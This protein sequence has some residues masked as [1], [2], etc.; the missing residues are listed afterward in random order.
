LPAELL[1]RPRPWIARH[2]PVDQCCDAAKRMSDAITLHAIAGSA[3]KWVLIKLLDGS[4]VDRLGLYP[5]RVTAE[6][7][8]THPAQIAIMI[9]PGGFRA[10]E[11]EEVIHYHREVYD[12]IGQRPLEIGY[13]MP[14]TRRDRRAQLRAFKRGR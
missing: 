10:S 6:A 1:D 3:G 12:Q 5:D 7:R 11:C 14:L 4:L 13:L 8:K 9:P 2:H